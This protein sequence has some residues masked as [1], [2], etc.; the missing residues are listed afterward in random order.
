[1]SRQRKGTIEEAVATAVKQ[2]HREQQGRGPSD[3]RA[4]LVGYLLLIRCI[5]ILTPTETHLAPTEDGRKLIKSARQELHNIIH[6]DIEGIIA[7]I[8]DCPVLRSYCDVDVN[9]AEQIEVYVLE[10]DVEKRLIHADLDLIAGMGARR[11]TG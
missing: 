3:V 11:S 2:F 10:T 4:H 5:G 6:K 7:G 1:M 9:A 8:V